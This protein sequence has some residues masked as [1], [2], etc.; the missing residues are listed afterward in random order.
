MYSLF[1]GSVCECLFSLVKSPTEFK[2]PEGEIIFDMS[3]KKGGIAH[4]RHYFSYQEMHIFPISYTF[5]RLRNWIRD[6]LKYPEKYFDTG[7]VD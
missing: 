6:T 4:L 1:Y 2:F 7:K 3:E 5:N